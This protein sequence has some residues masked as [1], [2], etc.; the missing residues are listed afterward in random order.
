MNINPITGT[1]FP[2]MYMYVHLITPRV[3]KVSPRKAIQAKA[4]SNQ[5]N[6]FSYVTQ[7]VVGRACQHQNNA[8]SRSFFTQREMLASMPFL[9]Y[10]VNLLSPPSLPARIPNTHYIRHIHSR[11][12]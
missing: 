2:I 11:V 3:M 9:R 1:C 10:L 4:S 8:N 7:R 12:S 5:A 6:R